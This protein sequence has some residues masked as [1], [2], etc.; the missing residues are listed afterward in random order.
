MKI[1]VQLTPSWILTA[2]HPA[3][4]YGIPVLVNRAN[5]HVAY[6]PADIV[7]F[8]PGGGGMQTA[9]HFVARFG[10]N[11]RGEERSAAASFLKQQWDGPQLD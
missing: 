9:A 5:P 1:L 8:P 4:S 11:L 6:G 10:K 7:D 3:S 2:E